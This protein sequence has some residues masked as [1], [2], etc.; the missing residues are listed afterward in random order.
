MKH[1]SN[2]FAGVMPETTAISQEEF[3]RG[4]RDDLV[5]ATSG[6]ADFVVSRLG[7]ME[8]RKLPKPPSEAKLRPLNEEVKMMITLH[9]KLLR[10]CTIF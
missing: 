4:A 1:G 7:W 10:L 6:G 2:V 5:R 8:D 3:S 9:R